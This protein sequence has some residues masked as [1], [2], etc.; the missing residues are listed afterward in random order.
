MLVGVCNIA[1]TYHLVLICQ[2]HCHVNT[3]FVSR[4][5]SVY[6]TVI[7]IIGSNRNRHGN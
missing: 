2:A 3:L 4:I 1:L 5:N 7:P 6:V